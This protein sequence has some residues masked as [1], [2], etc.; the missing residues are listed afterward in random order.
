M[1]VVHV[2]DKGR[3]LGALENY[4]LYIETQNGN[5]TNDKLTVQRNPIFEAYFNIPPYRGPTRLTQLE[6]T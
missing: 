2:A 1:E 4:Y 6:R 5:Q 3:L